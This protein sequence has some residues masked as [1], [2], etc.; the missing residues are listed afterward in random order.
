[1]AKKKTCLFC[2]D[3]VTGYLHYNFVNKDGNKIV[4]CDGCFQE[5]GGMKKIDGVWTDFVYH[6]NEEYHMIKK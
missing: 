4:L 3:P 5:F 2:D 1:M 6:N